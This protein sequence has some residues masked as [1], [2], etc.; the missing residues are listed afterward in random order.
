MTS[1]MLLLLVM[2]GVFI[3]SSQALECYFCVDFT[4]NDPDHETR[5]CNGLCTTVVFKRQGELRLVLSYNISSHGI[6]VDR[7]N[8]K[9]NFAH[10]LRIGKCS[11][12]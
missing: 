11:V 12:H 9:Y 8:F 5:N 3:E 4:C 2:F 6:N 7:H 1:V 10:V